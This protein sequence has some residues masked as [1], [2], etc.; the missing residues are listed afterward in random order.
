[1]S[2][3][4]LF[5]MYKM[6]DISAETSNKAEVSVIRVQENDDVNKTRLLLLCISD[7]SKR[8]SSK[9]IHDLI[10]KE[11]KGKYRVEKTSELIKPQIRKYKIGKARLL[12]SSKHSMYVHKDILIPIIM[13]TRLSDL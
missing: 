5:C 8:W 3:K 12:N 13:Q 9:N 4:I 1:M 10:D 7:V 11:I 2:L 6:V